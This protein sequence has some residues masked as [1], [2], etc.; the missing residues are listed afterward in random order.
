MRRRGWTLL[1]HAC[2]AGQLKTLKAAAD[3]AEAAD[4]SGF[5][6]NDWAALLAAS[7]LDR[8]GTRARDET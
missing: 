2:L 5:E 1:F 6:A 4:P 7:H 8:P 3:R